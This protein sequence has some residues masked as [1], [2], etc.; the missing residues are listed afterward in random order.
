MIFFVFVGCLYG[1]GVG[2]D[3][4]FDVCLMGNVDWDG[5]GVYWALLMGIGAFGLRAADR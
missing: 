3:G 5:H 2:C 4:A 1:I